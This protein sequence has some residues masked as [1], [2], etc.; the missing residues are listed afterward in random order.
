MAPGSG[1]VAIVTGATHGLGRALAH[2]LVKEEGYNTALSARSVQELK[3]LQAELSHYGYA[4]MV[5]A[6]D[7]GDPWKCSQ[8]VQDVDEAYDRID[9]LVNNAGYVHKPTD[10]ISLT[11][12]ELDACL[13]TNLYGP[14]YLMQDV[15]PI[16]IRQDSGTVV[17]IASKAAHFPVELEAAYNASKAAL[18]ALTRTVA[19]ELGDG[20]IKVIS[21]S[22]GGMSTRMRAIVWGEEDAAQQQSPEFVARVIADIVTLNRVV[23]NKLTFRA[24]D[25]IQAALEVPNGADVLVWRNEVRVFPMEELK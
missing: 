5:R 13:R 1:K 14:F 11:P 22:P 4:P 17:N 25:T 18:V 23:V 8:F 6:F 3:A 15:L 24:G 20:P 10:L 7:V 16:M 19:R 2:A 12:Q 21:V 9:V